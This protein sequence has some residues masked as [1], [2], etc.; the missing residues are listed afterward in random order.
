MPSPPAQTAYTNPAELWYFNGTP[1][2]DPHG[3]WNIS[4]MGGSRFGLPVLRGQ[5]VAVPY[6]AGQSWAPKYLDA[7][8]VTLTMWADGQGFGGSGGS[9]PSGSDPRLAFNSNIQQ[10]RA[11]FLTRGSTGSLQGKL[12]RNWY[13]M[14]G[15]VGTL[16]TATAMAE[17]AGSMDLTM[18]GRTNA[19]FSVDL[20]LA[21][22]Y[23]YGATATASVTTSGTV[24]NLG[25]GVAGEGWPSAVNAFTVSVTSPC[26]VSNVSA[27]CSFIVA[28]GPSFPVTVDVLNQTVV[29]NAG[30]N[31]V[32][33]F[34]HAGSRLWMALVSGA[35]NF[36]VSAGTATFTYCPPYV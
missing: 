6:R 14:Q 17:I 36:G 33:Y 20:L 3:A 8:T 21:D 35:N 7:R 32:Q 23:F 24:T 12:Q 25:E 18:N 28:A 15:G 11:L 30:A 10:L 26:I 4:T 22:P 9:Y 29:D 19:A 5:N 34:S 2:Q 27:G 1:L 31:Q 16:V 13:F